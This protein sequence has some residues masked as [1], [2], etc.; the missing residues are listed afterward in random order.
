M[1][2]NVRRSAAAPFQTAVFWPVSA[3]LATAVVLMLGL[4]GL[5]LEM[6]RDSDSQAVFSANLVA[7]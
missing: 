3:L 4:T 2:P 5:A 1:P 7:D 6:S